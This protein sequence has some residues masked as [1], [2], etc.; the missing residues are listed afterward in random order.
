MTEGESINTEKN[1]R[2]IYFYL[3]LFLPYLFISQCIILF[4]LSF[5]FYEFIY[6][7]ILHIF[8]IFYSFI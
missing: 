1:K 4:I 7:H 8:I 3:L 2:D 5:L 6:L